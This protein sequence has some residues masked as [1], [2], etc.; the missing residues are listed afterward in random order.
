GGEPGVLRIER[1]LL[2]RDSA[3]DLDGRRLDLELRLSLNPGFQLA[4][5]VSELNLLGREWDRRRR[6]LG[7]L[8]PREAPQL[9]ARGQVPQA[10][11]VILAR[12][13]QCFAIGPESNEGDVG[14]VPPAD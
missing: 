11:G 3:R 6:D 1:A 8:R 12:R 7:R 13:D 10:D 2:T 14:P 5:H 9:F 4:L